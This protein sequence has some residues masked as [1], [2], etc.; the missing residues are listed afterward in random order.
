L[1][2]GALAQ[3]DPAFDQPLR[4]CACGAGVGVELLNLRGGGLGGTM[5]FS[6]TGTSSV[7]DWSTF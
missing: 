5:D 1:D 7:A 3:F 6:I 2:S 4:L